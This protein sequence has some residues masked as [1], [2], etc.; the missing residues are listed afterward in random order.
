VTQLGH[1]SGEE[2]DVIASWLGVDFDNVE[3]C[4]IAAY[5]VPLHELDVDVDDCG[6]V[7]FAR[8]VRCGR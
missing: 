8:E 5:L 3:D 4:C 2:I 7:V 6:Y 1:I